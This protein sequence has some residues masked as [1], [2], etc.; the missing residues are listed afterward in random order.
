MISLLDVPCTNGVYSHSP[1]LF[2]QHH[3]RFALC[4]M[5]N[6]ARN[7]RYDEQYLC[8][9]IVCVLFIYIQISGMDP[10]RQISHVLIL[11]ILPYLFSW[12]SCN[13][14]WFVSC[15]HYSGDN[16]I[17]SQLVNHPVYLTL[18]MLRFL[19]F[20]LISFKQLSWQCTAFWDVS[21]MHCARSTVFVASC[22]GQGL[23]RE[24]VNT[25]SC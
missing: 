23:A 15:G 4:N 14:A 19:H 9:F 1:F 22:V 20:F 17:G 13:T 12:Y 5:D 7:A 2:T 11:F 24:E 10:Q 8:L 18:F 16:F 21:V 3:F 6:R 25:K